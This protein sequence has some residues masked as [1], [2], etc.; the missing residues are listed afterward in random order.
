[1]NIALVVVDF[2]NQ[3]ERFWRSFWRNKSKKYLNYGYQ[4][5]FIS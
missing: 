5:K 3:K 1:M 2:W 4:F